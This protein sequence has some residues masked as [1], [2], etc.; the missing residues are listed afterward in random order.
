MEKINKNH[1]VIWT[2][3]NYF[4]WVKYMLEYEGE[5]EEDLTW[6]RYYGEAEIHLQDERM[7]LNV[8]VDGVI[9]AYCDLGLWDGRHKGS[10][11]IGSNVK[12]ILQSKCDYLDWY[13]DRY[14]VRCKG[15]HHDG[16]NY[17][18]YRV[19]KNEETARRLMHKIVDEEMTEKE[20]MRATKSL[21]PYVAQVYGW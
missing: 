9:V 20:F 21:R 2:N 12:D 8:S 4:D 11:I 6:K 13:C 5:K 18:L 7:N 1:R 3:H 14:N 10:G 15:I 19:A 17:Y 16:T